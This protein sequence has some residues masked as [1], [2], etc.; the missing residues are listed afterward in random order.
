M[1]SGSAETPP[2]MR[3]AM[4]APSLQPTERRVAESIAADIESA[5][6]RTAQEVADI[7]GVGRASVIRTAQSLGY[8]GSTGSH[9][10]LA[11]PSLRSRRKASTRSCAISTMRSACSLRRTGCPHRSG[12]TSR[13]A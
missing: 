1:W 7:V 4:L 3:I 11:T 10:D 13:C 2:T 6:E 8:E 5:I 9:R 12:S